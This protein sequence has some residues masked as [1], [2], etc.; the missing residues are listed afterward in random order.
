M[1][2]LNYDDLLNNSDKF[3]NQWSEVLGISFDEIKKI[4][5]LNIKEN[6]SRT[7]NQQMVIESNFQTII[8]KNIFY[9]NLKSML[10][11]VIRNRLRDLF[12]IKKNINEEKEQEMKNIIKGYYYESNKEFE[13][14]TGVKIIW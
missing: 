5:P 13:T 3:L 6:P 8:R 9:K 11:R 7:Q 4:L 2:I 14:K 10:P 1:Y 12:Y